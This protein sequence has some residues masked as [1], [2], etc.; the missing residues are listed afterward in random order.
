MP[1]GGADIQVEFVARVG[2]LPETLWA[3]CFPAPLEGRFWYHTLENCGLEQQFTFYYALIKAAGRPVGIA[4]CFRHEVPISLVAPAPV[5]WVLRQLARVFPRVGYQHTFFVGSPCG[6]EGTIGLGRGVALADVINPL[7]EAIVA[8]ACELGTPMIVFKDF[9]EPDLAVLTRPSRAGEFV[10][11]V[12]Y[13]GTVVAL[14]PGGKE[15]YYRSL[16]HN[17]RHNLLKKLRRSR[18]RLPLETSVV[19][20][21]NARELAEVF[22]LFRQTYERGRTKFERLGPEF[23]AQIAAQEPARFILQRDPVSGGLVTFMLV[24]CLGDRVVNK[25]IGLDYARGGDTYLYFR[26]FDAALDFACARGAQE[27]QSGQTGYRAK[28][29]LGHR[30][31][32]LGNAFHHRWRPVHVLFR[33]IGRRITLGSLDSDLARHF[34]PAD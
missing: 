17:R 18:E 29:D 4:P 27:L 21:P 10:P 32:P 23:F 5:A 24:F 28:F 20:Q 8:K 26:L 11:S 22:G 1:T 7:R 33:T 3:D 31:V 2:D 6:E 16:T 14:P 15:A 12:S 34:D 19:A 9:P 25:F 30:L 13:P